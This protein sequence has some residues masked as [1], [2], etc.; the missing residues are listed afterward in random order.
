MDI[1][2]LILIISALILAVGCATN[3]LPFNT[4]EDKFDRV[5]IS[6]LWFSIFFDHMGSFIV[7]LN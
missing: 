3:T 6:L 7:S 2:S 5:I 1:F 4:D